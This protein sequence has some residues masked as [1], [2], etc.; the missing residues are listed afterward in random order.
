MNDKE[1]RLSTNY[2]SNI[3]IIKSILLQVKHE[4]N[5]HELNL[6]MAVK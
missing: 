5:V 6:Y 4:S 1:K 2:L 3:K